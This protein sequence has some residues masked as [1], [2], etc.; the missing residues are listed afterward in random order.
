MPVDPA[1][2]SAKIIKELVDKGIIIESGWEILRDNFVN[3]A[4]PGQSEMRFA[5]FSG[6]QL[7]FETMMTMIQANPA[8]TENDI[9]HMASQIDKELKRFG[10]A[11]NTRMMMMVKPQGSA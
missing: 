3:Q 10:V 2:L 9:R 6:A 11:E 4:E 1:K 8:P 5:F 7:L